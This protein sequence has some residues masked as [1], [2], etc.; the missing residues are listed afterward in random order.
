[1][2]AFWQNWQR[3]QTAAAAKPKFTA[4]AALASVATVETEWNVL[5]PRT[6]AR[7]ARGYV[8]NERIPSGEKLPLVEGAPTALPA[9]VLSED[10]RMEPLLV[11]AGTA[12]AGRPV[13]GKWSAKGAIVSETGAT[14]APAP[15]RKPWNAPYSWPADEPVGALFVLEAGRVKQVVPLAAPQFPRWVPAESGWIAEQDSDELHGDL[16]GR[17]VWSADLRVEVSFNI[18]ASGRTL[19][20]KAV[21]ESPGFLLA[22]PQFGAPLDGIHVPPFDDG[23]TGP[24]N[25]RAIWL[26]GS[27]VEAGTIEDAP[28]EGVVRLNASLCQNGGVVFDDEG[29]VLALCSLDPRANTGNSTAVPVRRGLDL[30]KGAGHGQSW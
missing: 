19:K 16:R 11:R 10:R 27:Q 9:F 23:A 12:L 13:G 25:S 29:R 21:D 8:G 20:A 28:A 17:R 24:R 14:L 2:P 15:D 18:T 6:G 1:M 5:D 26:V 30:L 3:A 22:A 4:A 7:L